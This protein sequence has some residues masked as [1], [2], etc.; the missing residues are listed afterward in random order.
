MKTQFETSVAVRPQPRQISSN[1]VEQI[2]TQG[3]SV[4]AK[5]PGDEALSL[6]GVLEESE[7]I[8]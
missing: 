2:A 7:L 1:S 4:A 8:G 6:E 3:E 5:T